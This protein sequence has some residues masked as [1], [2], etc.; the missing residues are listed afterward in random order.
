MIYTEEVQKLLKEIVFLKE[1]IENRIKTISV[2]QLNWKPDE[3]SWSIAECLEH[4]R[5]TDIAYIPTLD[6]ALAEARNQSINKE[7]AHSSTF[8]ENYL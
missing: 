2:Q 8:L 1:T 7:G 4:L 5:N 6:K 3:R